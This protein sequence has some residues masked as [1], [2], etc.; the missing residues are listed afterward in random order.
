VSVDSEFPLARRSLC[1]SPSGGNARGPALHPRR[2][3]RLLPALIA[4]IALVACGRAPAPHRQSQARSPAAVAEPVL[5]RSPLDSVVQ[6]LLAA[7]AADFHAHRPPDPVRFRDVRVG[8]IM[9]ADGAPLYMLCG[10]F[11]P[12]PLGGRAEWTPFATIRTSRYE[13]WL[14]AQS[15]AFCLG[16]SVVWDRAADLS[17]HRGQGVRSPS[18]RPALALCDVLVVE[19]AAALQLRRESVRRH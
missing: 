9:R 6:F 5:Q 7:A 4:T 11:L 19:R 10:Q 3:M 17:P 16:A 1:A 15:A 2:L 8:H 12:A 13:Q 18:T 14:G